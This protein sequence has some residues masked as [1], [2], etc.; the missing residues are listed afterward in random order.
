MHPGGLA[1]ADLALLVGGIAL[2]VAVLFLGLSGNKRGRRWLNAIGWLTLIL[3]V[4]A[5][6][7]GT[8]RSTASSS[9]TQ[10]A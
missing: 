4:G 9:A 6:G 10:A 3:S 2:V 7:Y 5:L 1:T 8:V